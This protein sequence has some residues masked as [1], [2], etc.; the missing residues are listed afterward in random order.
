MKNPFLMCKKVW[1]WFVTWTRFMLVVI[2]LAKVGMPIGTDDLGQEIMDDIWMRC[3]II[4]N[5]N[6]EYLSMV[7]YNKYRKEFGLP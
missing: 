7:I 3:H 1:R 6:I 2:S 4:R 5:A